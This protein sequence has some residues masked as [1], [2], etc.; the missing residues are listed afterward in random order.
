MG[1]IFDTAGIDEKLTN[2]LYETIKNTA[3]AST[4]RSIREG[5]KNKKWG[6]IVC[7]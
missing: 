4:I 2:P 7:E 5:K 3:V 1:V 6:I